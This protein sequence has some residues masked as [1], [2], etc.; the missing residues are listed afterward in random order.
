M[1]IADTSAPPLNPAT[2]MLDGI[3]LEG[4]GV[5]PGWV[6]DLESYRR[7]A[8]SEEFPQ[9]G[10]FFY[11]GNEIWVDLQMEELWTHNQVKGAFSTDLLI[12][13]RA[14]RSGRF[15]FDRMLLTNPSAGL[16]TEPDGLFYTWE[17]FQSG[18]L[19]E[20]PGASGQE[21]MELEGTPDVVLE[22][23]SK[24]SVKKDTQRLPELYWRA[25][26]TEFWL[27]DV[28]GGIL[29]FDIL[30]YTS[31]GYQETTAVDGWLTS[32]VFAH[33]FQLVK[34]SDPVGRPEYQVLSR[35]P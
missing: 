21:V 24:S 34:G 25:G 12:L 20:V 2:P 28:R 18:R 33:Q 14:M 22:I 6:R 17:T 26:I 11:L 32:K 7:W 10:Q 29:K 1:T 23:V 5:I 9:K 3:V 15:I 16:S 19:R 35:K 30:Q 31:Q 13:V 27:V 8:W 4:H